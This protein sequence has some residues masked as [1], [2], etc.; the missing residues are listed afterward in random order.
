MSSTA[1]SRVLQSPQILLNSREN[2]KGSEKP[3]IFTPSFYEKTGSAARTDGPE[4]IALAKRLKIELLPWQKWLL[5]YAFEKDLAG[6]PIN[7]TVLLTV[8]R[9]NGKSTLLQLIILWY[10]TKGKSVL[11]ST[12]TLLVASTTQEWL[13]QLSMEHPELFRN[14]GQENYIHPGKHKGTKPG[15]TRVISTNGRWSGFCPNG[16]SWTITASSSVGGRGKSTDVLVVDELRE[17]SDESWASLS[18]TILTSG[19]SFLASNSGD[20][21]SHVLNRIRTSAVNGLD[22][23]ALY[24]W[25]ATEG[26]DISSTED[27]LAANPAIGHLPEFTL[28]QFKKSVMPPK[29]DPNTYRTENL[30]Q[31]VP[32]LNN[33]I[34]Q[35]AW[36]NCTDPGSQGLEVGTVV[37]SL[38][39]S[40]D[41]RHI[42]LVIAGKDPSGR[43]RA[44]VAGAWTS[45]A[46]MRKQLPVA[47][48]KYQPLQLIWNPT[49]PAAAVG[50]DIRAL[51]LRER[52]INTTELKNVCAV[53]AETVQ[54][55]N[56]AHDGDALLT[57][58]ACG[59]SKLKMG[60][61][62]VM[63]RRNDGARCDAAYAAAMCVY[64]LREQRKRKPPTALKLIT[65]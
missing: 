47:I 17:T 25:S 65:T 37:A 34:D 44:R 38:D 27:I 52:P 43:I 5:M 41:L 13:T 33:A 54:A 4:I 64:F 42:T 26:C 10:L 60:D 29:Q 45:A 16:G 6:K 59:A 50:P 7:S 15:F 23:T 56:F 1:K 46:E 22:G 14:P 55:G 40:S 18:S 2:L 30:N 19:R 21:S 12:V 9:Q 24:E 53:F 57:A 8:A 20:H 61:G 63:S 32:T 49:G 3:R 36:K 35:I 48:N 58:H 11:F 51:K 62:W 39:V 28:E 31:F